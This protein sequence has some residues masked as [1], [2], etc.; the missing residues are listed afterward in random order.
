MACSSAAVT[1]RLEFFAG[2]VGTPLAFNAPGSFSTALRSGSALTPNSSAACAKGAQVSAHQFAIDGKRRAA[3]ALQAERDF[4]VPAVQTLFQ[5]AAHLHLQL[6]QFVRE[7][8]GAD[9]G[10]DGL[11]TSGSA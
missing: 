5:H 7:S 10:N 2:V 8:A 6:V 4:D 11:P 9:R 3:G 1:C